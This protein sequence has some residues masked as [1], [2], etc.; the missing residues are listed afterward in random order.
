MKSLDR[1]HPGSGISCHDSGT[2]HRPPSTASYRSAHPKVANTV[3]PF[4]QGAVQPDWF[5]AWSFRHRNAFRRTAS[6]EPFDPKNSLR[7][8]QRNEASFEVIAPS[9]LPNGIHSV[10]QHKGA[11]RALHPQS[12]SLARARWWR[13][14]RC[15]RRLQLTHFLFSKTSTRVLCGYHSRFPVHDEPP[16]FTAAIRFGGPSPN[17]RRGCYSP[18]A[19]LDRTSDAP[20]SSPFA[21]LRA[22]GSNQ[23]CTQPPTA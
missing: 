2:V 8:P 19:A 4:R 1:E 16:L 23:A 20:S 10:R 18:S 5:R 22:P 13:E 7:S 3:D 6:F 14:A 15:D 17:L 12:N 21:F 11:F 9:S